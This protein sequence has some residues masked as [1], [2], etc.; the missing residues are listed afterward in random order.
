V[1]SSP[2]VELYYDPFDYEVDD[3]PYPVWQ[4]MRAEAPLYFN[5]KYNFYALSRY[6]DVR[7][8]KVAT[9]ALAD[10][11]HDTFGTACPLAIRG[12]L[13]A[14]RGFRCLR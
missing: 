10:S 8:L 11:W 7:H 12:G 9:D 1:A 5:D 14:G 6:D 2:T 4:R 13:P 3:D